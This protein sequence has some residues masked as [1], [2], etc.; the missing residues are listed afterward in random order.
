[1]TR[2]HVH[3]RRA[4]VAMDPMNWNKAANVMPIGTRV[5]VYRP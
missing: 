2:A 3:A 1:M 5:R 4:R